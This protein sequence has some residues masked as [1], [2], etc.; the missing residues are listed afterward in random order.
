[1]RH[2]E[3]LSTAVV[4]N[5]FSQQGVGGSAGAVWGVVCRPRDG[6][7]LWNRHPP[8]PLPGYRP[9]STLHCCSQD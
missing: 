2:T 8:V 4:G 6:P 3:Q 9:S 7:A 1:V 5:F